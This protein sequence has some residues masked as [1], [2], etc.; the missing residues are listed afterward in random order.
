MTDVKTPPS[1]R[2]D[3][4]NIYDNPD[5]F[6][7][8]R[9]LRMNDSGL[10]GALEEPAIRR[11]LPALSGLSVVDLGCG[12]GH[13]ARWAAEHGAA[14]VL[15]VDVSA[16][17]LAEAERLTKDRKITYVHSAMEELALQRA[18]HDLVVSSM[19]L[20]YVAGYDHIVQTAF[21]GLRPG[22]RFVFSVEHPI[23]T[24]D[25]QGWWTN[26]AGDALHWPLDRYQE[27]GAR[28]TRWFVDGVEKQHRTVSDYVNG[29]IAGGFTI[30]ALDE[31]VPAPD[32]LHRRPDLAREF[33]RPSMLVLSAARPS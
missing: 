5:F 14:D 3:P 19:A 9:E 8:Y 7:G 30:L 28:R 21:D 1:N 22:G 17:M 33:R 31:P 23:C 32:A 26:Q 10:N 25:P 13:F 20:H 24:A 29:L 16:R 2:R 6:R 11:H 27:R 18:N 15:A 12:F 4:G